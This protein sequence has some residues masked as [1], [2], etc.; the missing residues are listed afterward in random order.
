MEIQ[1]VISSKK[2]SDFELYSNKMINK[3]IR[4]NNEFYVSQVYNEYIL[5]N[6][7]VLHYPIV[8]IFSINTPEELIENK[9]KISLFL[10]SKLS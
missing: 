5:D 1:D 10:K 9:K 3:N 7:K 6:K 8:E 4:I 2:T